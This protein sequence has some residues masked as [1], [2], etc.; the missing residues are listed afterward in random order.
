MTYGVEISQKFYVAVFAT[1]FGTFV[2]GLISS[3]VFNM[4]Y[5]SEDILVSDAFTAGIYLS[6]I[7]PVIGIFNN[8]FGMPI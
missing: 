2:S 8:E 4:I 7:L 5:V 1:A 6:E 3:F